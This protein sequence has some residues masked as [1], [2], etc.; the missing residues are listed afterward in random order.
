VRLGVETDEYF[1]EHLILFNYKNEKEEILAQLEMSAAE[2]R[3]GIE[4]R[5]PDLVSHVAKDHNLR[6]LCGLCPYR[7]RCTQMRISAGEL[8]PKE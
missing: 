2:L 8:K 6:W 7:E 4:Q 5:R 1:K 3:N